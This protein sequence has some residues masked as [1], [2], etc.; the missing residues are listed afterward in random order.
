MKPKITIVLWVLVIVIQFYGYNSIAQNQVAGFDKTSFNPVF[1]QSL[2]K[3]FRLNI[4]MYTQFRYNMNFRENIPDSVETFSRGY[5]LA[6]TRIFFEGNYTDKFYYHF[7]FNINPSGNIELLVAYLQYNIKSNMWIR[8]G[9]QFMALGREDWILPQNL[10]SIEFSAHNFTYA[11]WSSFG[12]QFQHSPSDNFRYW[13]SIGNGAYGG[14]RQ[15]PAPKDAD[16]ALTARA[17]YNIFGTNWEVW[18]DMLGRKGT[19]FGMLLG[20]G[21]GFLSRSKDADLITN[22][23][24]AYQINLDYSITGN[25]FHF[26]AHGSFTN[27]SFKGISEQVSGGGFYST[28]GYWLNEYIFP[29]ARFDY[30][31]KG[32]NLGFSED[33]VSPGLGISYYPF[34]WSNRYRFSLEYN[35]L[36]GIVNFTPVEPDGQLGLVQSFWGKQQSIMLQMQFGF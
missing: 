28:F 32:K 36:S 13:A 8:L 35:R 34:K 33:Y 27:R 26:Y 2:D 10:A 19:D 6:R 29:Y 18:D 30:V 23:E 17:E 16:V 15:F 25:G 11:I 1:I 9:K 24:K 7:R 14:R 21:G 5:N 12:F 22:A 20:L 4:G 31:S 3:E